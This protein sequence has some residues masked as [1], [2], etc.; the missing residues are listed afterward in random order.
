MRSPV[1]IKPLYVDCC[2]LP[3]WSGTAVVRREPARHRLHSG[4]PDAVRHSKAMR[5]IADHAAPQSRDPKDKHRGLMGLGSAAH[6]AAKAI[7]HRRRA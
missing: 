7:A 3:A 1:G 6:H 2:E 5:G 4:V